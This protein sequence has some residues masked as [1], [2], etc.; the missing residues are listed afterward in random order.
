MSQLKIIIRPRYSSPPIYGARVISHI[1]ADQELAT[2]WR[3]D[4]R[5]MADRIIDMRTRLRD[6]LLANGSQKN[7]E[8]ITDQIGMFCFTGLTS[9]QVERLKNEYA[10]YLTSNGRISVAG[11]TSKNVDYLATAM[12]E[13]TK[14]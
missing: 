6:G 1:L 14:E 5:V 12:H 9:P 11:V 3:K 8:H 7:W 10:I 2:E 13:V 4:V